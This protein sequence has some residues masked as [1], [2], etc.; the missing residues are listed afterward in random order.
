MPDLSPSA[1]SRGQGCSLLMMLM[2]MM[3]MRM[4]MGS[5]VL[6]Q[7][8]QGQPVAIAGEAPGDDAGWGLLA[9]C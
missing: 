3:L 9:A 6:V 2:L 1:G 4:M 8:Q 5:A 7:T